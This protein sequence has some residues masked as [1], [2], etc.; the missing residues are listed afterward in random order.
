MQKRMH[1]IEK[2]YLKGSRNGK[3][4][5]RRRLGLKSITKCVPVIIFFLFLFVIVIGNVLLEIRIFMIM[6]DNIGNGFISI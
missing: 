4:P 6:P 2:R 3:Q 5:V 1:S